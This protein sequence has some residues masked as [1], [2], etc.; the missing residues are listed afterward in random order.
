[1]VRSAV[2][3]N[4][5]FLPNNRTKIAENCTSVRITTKKIIKQNIARKKKYPDELLSAFCTEISI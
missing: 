3:I 5:T 2:K 1:L 4:Y